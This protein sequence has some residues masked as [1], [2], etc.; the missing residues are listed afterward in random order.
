MPAEAGQSFSM[1]Q[2]FSTIDFTE[3]LLKAGSYRLKIT[4]DSKRYT[5]Y[6]DANFNQ[7]PI[8]ADCRT[9]T[10]SSNELVL[11]VK[12]PPDR[13]VKKTFSVKGKLGTGPGPVPTATGREPRSEPAT[14]SSTLNFGRPDDEQA[15]KLFHQAWNLS[16]QGLNE[17]IEVIATGIMLSADRTMLLVKTFKTADAKEAKPDDKAKKTFSVKGNLGIWRTDGPDGRCDNGSATADDRR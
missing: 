8:P 14:A 6:N 16:Q 2:P 12:P 4:Y 5:R 15:K 17:T 10:L 7:Q 13:K 1:E 3:Y 9:G 11:R